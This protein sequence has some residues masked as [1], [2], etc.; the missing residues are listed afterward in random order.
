MLPS[1]PSCTWERACPRN[2][3]AVSRLAQGTEGTTKLPNFS[4][5]PNWG[6]GKISEGSSRG[7]A[8]L[9]RQVRSQV[10]LGNEGTRVA[11]SLFFCHARPVALIVSG[12]RRNTPWSSG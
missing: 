12:S 4:K 1:F 5:F 6:K 2:S 9:R 8:Q 11:C 3:V 10:Q 7:E